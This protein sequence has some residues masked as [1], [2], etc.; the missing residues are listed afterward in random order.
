MFTTYFLSDLCSFPGTL[1]GHS[2]RGRVIAEERLSHLFRDFE[3]VALRSIFLSNSSS[4]ITGVWNAELWLT[5]HVILCAAP[6]S[7]SELFHCPPVV[8]WIREW[9]ASGGGIAFCALM[10]RKYWSGAGL[11]RQGTFPTGQR[12]PKALSSALLSNSESPGLSWCLHPKQNAFKTEFLC[13]PVDRSSSVP[14][15]RFALNIP[16]K[17][18]EKVVFAQLL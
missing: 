18:Q 4:Y 8:A 1:R 3:V 13:E 2:S 10:H 11:S 6:M 17:S 9:P 12:N 7:W 14:V 16:V 5:G 15:T